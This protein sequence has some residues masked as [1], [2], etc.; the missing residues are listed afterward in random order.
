MYISLFIVECEF[1]LQMMHFVNKS[2]AWSISV[3]QHFGTLIAHSAN[4]DEKVHK[5]QS[6][7]SRRQGR[8]AKNAEKQKH[9]LVSKYFF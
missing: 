5:P 1:F 2:L 7:S 8:K 3:L 6:Q 9:Y 4:F